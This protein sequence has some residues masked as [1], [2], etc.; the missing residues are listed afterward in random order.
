MKYVVGGL[1]IAYIFYMQWLGILLFL[2]ATL[3]FLKRVASSPIKVVVWIHIGISIIWFFRNIFVASSASFGYAGL[4]ELKS[5]M[6]FFF[7]SLGSSCQGEISDSTI[8]I[9]FCQALLS[10]AS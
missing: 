4:V 1:W 8:S 6:S 5:L 2:A 9:Y 3:A 10:S 7:T